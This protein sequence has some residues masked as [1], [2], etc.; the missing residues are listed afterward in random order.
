MNVLL[1]SMLVYSA[2]ACFA[3]C[4]AQESQTQAETPP[5]EI[6]K[7]ADSPEPPLKK[8]TIYTGTIYDYEDENN[9]IELYE[10]PDK[11]SPVLKVYKHDSDGFP[12]VEVELLETI[13][14]GWFKVKTDEQLLAFVDA[15]NIKTETIPPHDYDK[16]SAEW[17]I[18]FNHQEQI[19]RVYRNGKPQKESTSSSGLPQTFTP[20]GIFEIEKGRRGDYY[21]IPKFNMGIKYWVG[22]KHDFLFHSVPTDKNRNTLA[23]AFEELGQPATHGCI[24]LP[25]EVAEYIFINVPEHALVL[26]D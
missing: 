9:K 18:T 3:G 15:R 21:F 26:I 13:P 17:V 24:R 22:F 8:P 7:P 16:D 1:K 20:K 5:K 12:Q 19:T 25:D 14:F 23:S 10:K 2:V 6:G 11:K 4:P